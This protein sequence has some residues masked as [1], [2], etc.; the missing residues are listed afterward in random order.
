MPREREGTGLALGHAHMVLGSGCL[1]LVLLVPNATKQSQVTGTRADKWGPGPSASGSNH[2]PS[3]PRTF[4]GSLGPA[5]VP[6]GH[7]GPQAG[8]QKVLAQL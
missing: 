6:T 5:R 7:L 2:H 4:P 1:L 8:G 3:L